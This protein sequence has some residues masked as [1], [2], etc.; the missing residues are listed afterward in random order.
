MSWLLWPASLVSECEA[1]PGVAD[2]SV[3]VGFAC[4]PVSR[5]RKQSFSALNFWDS[6]G[7]VGAANLFKGVPISGLLFFL[8]AGVPL[9]FLYRPCVAANP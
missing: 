5:Q 4:A 3:P 7:K 6:C 2:D 1:K 9:A 8:G